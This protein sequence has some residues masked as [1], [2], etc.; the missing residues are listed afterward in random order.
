MTATNERRRSLTMS[1]VLFV[2]KANRGRSVMSQA[3]FVQAED[4]RRADPPASPYRR[5]QETGTS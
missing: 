3:L 2:C 4:A 1:T 5:H